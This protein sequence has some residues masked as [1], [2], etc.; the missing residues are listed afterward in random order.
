MKLLN[1][2]VR[3]LVEQNLRPLIKKIPSTGYSNAQYRILCRIIIQKKI[4]KAFFTFLL[5]QL[6]GLSDW[7]QL[8]YEQMYEFIHILSHWDYSKENKN[9]NADKF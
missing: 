3:T 8:N 7:K 2:D 1:Y 9:F 4:T 6:Y 5:Y